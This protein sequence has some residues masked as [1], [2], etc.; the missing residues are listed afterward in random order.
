MAVSIVTIIIIAVTVVFSLQGFSNYDFFQRY[1]FQTGPI[2]QNKQYDRLL[3]SGFLHVDYIHLILNMYVLYVFGDNLIVFFTQFTGSLLTGSLLFLLVYILAI[4]GGNLLAL[5]FHKNNPNYSAVG[6]SGGVSG[7]LFASIVI[8]PTMM[9]GVF[10]VIPMPAWIFAILYLGYSV[11]GVQKQL[12]N[13]G[14]EAHLGGAVIGLIAPLVFSPELLIQNKWYIIG[15]AIPLI[16]LLFMA[17]R[18]S[19]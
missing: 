14:H 4:L 2:L 6:A 17:L 13:T 10:F 18:A 8:Y 19:K 12:G 9:L 16:I 5:L 15:M 7:I 1:K 3:T 11:Y